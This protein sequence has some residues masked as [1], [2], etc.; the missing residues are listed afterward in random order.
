MTQPEIGMFDLVAV[1]DLL[2]KD[3]VMIAQPI[4]H[5]RNLH[6]RQRID[7]ARGETPEA[8]VAQ[9]SIRFLL[10]QL[11]QV[12]ALTLDDVLHDRLDQQI[13][14]IIGERPSEQELHRQ[15]VHLLRIFLIVGSASQQ[16]ARQK[17]AQ[18][19]GD[20][21]ETLAKSGAGGSTIWSKIKRR[22]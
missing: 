21:L 1:L 13:G 9:A 14:Q 7:E 19:T 22:S 3:T 11:Q 17:V 6:G 5:R 8:T 15:V 20:R 16:P 18:R 12:Q 10:R 4:A 2:A